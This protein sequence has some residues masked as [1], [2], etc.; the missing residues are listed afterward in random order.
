MRRTNNL[1]PTDR[2]PL[3]GVPPPAHAPQRT[4][5][6]SHVARRADLHPLVHPHIARERDVQP[7]E[8]HEL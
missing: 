4:A 2:Q 5:S 1:H 6:R 3:V 8:P 7:A